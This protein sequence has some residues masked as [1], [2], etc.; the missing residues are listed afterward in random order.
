[1]QGETI[2]CIA[3]RNWHALWRDT[4]SIMVRIAA[5]N[6]VLYFEPGRNPDKPVIAEMKR[7]F[8]SLFVLHTK[9]ETKNLIVILS[10]SSLPVVRRHLP[11]SVLKITTPIV[12]KLNAWNQIIHIKRT[13][14]ALNIKDPILW[15]Y[16]PFHIDMIGKFGEKLVCYYNYDEFSEFID[17][18]RIKDIIQ[19]FDNQL[20][21]KADVVFASSQAQ[22]KRRK[23]INHNTYFI[24][25]GVDFNLFNRALLPK[26]QLPDDIATIQRPIIGFAG[27]LGYHID[28]KLLCQVAKSYPNCSLVLIGPNALPKSKDLLKLYSLSNV[29]FLGGKKQSKLPNYLKAFDVALMPYLLNGHVRSAFPL[30]LHEYL[31]AGRSIVS[32]ALPELRPYEKLI[33]IAGSN[34]EFIHFINEAI[35]DKSL[36]A[37][38]ER[39]A[40][41]KEN[42]WDK[43]VDE[44]SRILQNKLYHGEK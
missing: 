8:S 38:E 16:S 4:Q 44:I 34:K 14:K 9:E 13:I 25:N 12:I 10:P 30:K 1:V 28:V 6:R 17:N 36:Q 24:P 33:Y 31:A 35:N 15:L 41:A 2:L 32:T 11:R 7:N 20:S 26:L 42:T 39:I 5:K 19:R 21:S 37:I 3:P 23:A 22:W 40:V 29:F 18:I 27:W 43:R